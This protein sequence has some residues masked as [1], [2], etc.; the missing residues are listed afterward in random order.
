[1]EATKGDSARAGLPGKAAKTNRK[2]AAADPVLGSQGGETKTQDYSCRSTRRMVSGRGFDS[3][4]LHHIKSRL[5]KELERKLAAPTPFDA[6]AGHSGDTS[7]QPESEPGQPKA[8]GAEELGHSRADGGQLATD[9][10]HESALIPPQC[11]MENEVGEQPSSP[12]PS[13]LE[14]ILEAWPRLPAEVRRGIVAMVEATR[15]TGD[16]AHSRRS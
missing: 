11:R 12:P 13:D 6:S 2:L 4:R 10:G 3:P 8:L 1:M 15:P 14:V 9:S 16:G 7:G 5:R